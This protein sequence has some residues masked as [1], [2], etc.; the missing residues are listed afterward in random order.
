M[1]KLLSVL[2]I[3]LLVFAL[4]G[5]GGSSD[6]E[7]GGGDAQETIVIKAAHVEVEDRAIHEGLV[8]FGEYIA[9]ESDGVLKLEIFPNGELGDDSDVV[10]SILLGTVQMT[11]PGSALFTSYDEKFAVMNL[12]YLFNSKEEMDAAFTGEFG[13]LLGEWFEEYGF[14]LLGFNYD[15]A[16]CMSNNVR[17]IFTPA[18]MKGIKY[19]VMDSNLYIDMFKYM[20]ANPTPMGYGEVYTALQQG[21]IDGQD[22]PPGLTYGSK[23]NEVLKYFSVTQHVYANCPAIIGADFFNS[24]D[25]EYQDIIAAGAKLYLED[26]QRGEES[27]AEEEY[28][29]LIK[30]AGTEVNYLDEAG[31]KAF[32]ESVQPLYDSYRQKL[33]DDIMDKVLEYAR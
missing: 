9:E 1:K 33:G 23:F 5:C 18:D 27:A 25:K 4:V 29:E 3:S 22:N 7:G 21:V 30:E 19:R 24:L 28:I 16:R 2:L 20:G 17:P 31:I 15:G 32:Q 26:W 8:K 13:D 10:E 11:V 14:K 6:G 12:P